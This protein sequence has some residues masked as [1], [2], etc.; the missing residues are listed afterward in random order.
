MVDEAVDEAVSEPSSDEVNTKLC[1]IADRRKLYENRSLSQI[2]EKKKSSATV[3][4]GESFKESDEQGK[5][6]VDTKSSHQSNGTTAKTAKNSKRTS[7]VFGKVSKFRH[8]K[9]TTGHKSTHIENIKNINRQLSGECD[10]FHGE[11]FQARNEIIKFKS[12][13]F[14]K[15][16]K[17]RSATVRERRKNCCF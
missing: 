10:G 4:R 15:P 8:L 3:G 6:R 5:D 9:G 2:D 12:F 7:T 1:S 13:N 16:R 14:S 17:S 11:I